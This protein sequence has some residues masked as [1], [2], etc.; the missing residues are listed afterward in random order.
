MKNE[1]IQKA[2]LEPE[3]IDVVFTTGGTSPIP[4]VKDP[5]VRRHRS[6]AGEIDLSGRARWYDTQNTTSPKLPDIDLIAVV[7]IR[8]SDVYK[9]NRG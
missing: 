7:S 5:F 4:R 8:G 1:T 6:I 3:D 9:K 2:G